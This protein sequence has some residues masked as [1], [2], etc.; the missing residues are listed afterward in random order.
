MVIGKGRGEAFAG[1]SVS[2]HT[3]VERTER[4][5]LPAG[6]QI[7]VPRF[8]FFFLATHCSGRP[9]S[10][11]FLLGISPG[12]LPSPPQAARADQ[13]PPS[14][15][16]SKEKKK[17]ALRQGGEKKIKKDFSLEYKCG[18]KGCAY[19]ETNL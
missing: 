7:S 4:L 19:L 12:Q 16:F 6:S 10:I 9:E 5:R 8:S 3:Q 2:R 18:R 17:L 1:D 11:P 15:R 14:H 13:G